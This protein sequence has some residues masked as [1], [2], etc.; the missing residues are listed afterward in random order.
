MLLSLVQIFIFFVFY[1]KGALL[2]F[3]SSFPGQ[4]KV[5]SKN[6]KYY[7][8][9]G[10]M[11]L[12]GFGG[13]GM[14]LTTEISDNWFDEPKRLMINVM[15]A[16]CPVLGQTL[17]GLVTPNVVTNARRLYIINLVCLILG[18]IGLLTSIT[19]VIKKSCS[20]WLMLVRR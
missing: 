6:S 18:L 8:A 20:L 5:F 4:E 14:A 3:L 19:K 9:L 12:N 2:C 16:T 13:F 11:A 1:V 15:F 10:G 7:L 17:N